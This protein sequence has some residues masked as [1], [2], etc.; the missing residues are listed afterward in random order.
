MVKNKVIGFTIGLASMTLL[1]GTAVKAEEFTG[2]LFSSEKLNGNLVVNEAS[3]FKSSAYA[4]TT[5]ESCNDKAYVYLEAK[6]VRGKRIC[7]VFNESWKTAKV[8]I[9]A[10]SGVKSFESYHSTFEQKDFW[11][12]EIIY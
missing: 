11:G 9:K 10:L 7:S 1:T 12:Y 2:E 3:P 6:D 5:Y 4:Y 8:D